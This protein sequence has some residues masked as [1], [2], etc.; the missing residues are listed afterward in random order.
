MF[1]TAKYRG[2]VRRTEGLK[3]CD[4]NS[5]KIKSQPLPLPSPAALRGVAQRYRGSALRA[6]GLKQKQKNEKI[7][8]AMS[9]GK[10]LK[11]TFGTAFQPLRHFVPPPL[12]HIRAQRRSTTHFLAFI[13][14][15]ATRQNILTFSLAVSRSIAGCFAQQK[16]RGSAHRARGL[17]Y[18]QDPPIPPLSGGEVARKTEEKWAR[19]V[20]TKRVPQTPTAT[21]ATNPK[22]R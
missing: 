19:T 10:R 5:N 4:S 7:E 15:Y 16:Y 6:R 17:E 22:A 20:R 21:A 8:S 9:R 11:E 14:F 2:G 18:K 13:V 3:N 1:C 12:S